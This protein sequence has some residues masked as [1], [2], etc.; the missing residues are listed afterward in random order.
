MSHLTTTHRSFRRI[1]IALGAFVFALGLA[2]LPAEAGRGHG[3]HDHKHGKSAH[4][5]GYGYGHAPGHAKGRLAFVN[6]PRGFHF[7]V[8]QQIRVSHARELYPYH[9]S[10]VYYAPHRHVH[11]VYDFPVRVSGGWVYQPYAYCGHDL[12]VEPVAPHRYVSVNSPRLS[13]SFGF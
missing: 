1:G 11:A 10:N 2:N 4:A 7:A 6:A 13:V 5:R 8:P 9:R 3:K 12:F